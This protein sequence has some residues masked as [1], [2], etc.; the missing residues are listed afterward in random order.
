MAFAISFT[1]CFKDRVFLK[2]YVV[3]GLHTIGET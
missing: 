3:I 2:D 1:V